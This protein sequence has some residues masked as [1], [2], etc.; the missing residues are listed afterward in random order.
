[1]VLAVLLAV[2]GTAFA[3]EVP[4][5]EKMVKDVKSE[6]EMRDLADAFRESIKYYMSRYDSESNRADLA[7]MY[8]YWTGIASLAKRGKDMGWITDS[9]YSEFVGIYAT[10]IMLLSFYGYTPLNATEDLERM[11][12]D[13][14]F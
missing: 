4:D 8:L 11:R 1:M 14:T 6:E 5:V 10:V 9:S 2:A 7:R 12:K 3:D 13:K